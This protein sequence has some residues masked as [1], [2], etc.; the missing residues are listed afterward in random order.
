MEKD[1][2]KKTIR[3]KYV[4]FWDSDAKPFYKELSQFYN[5]ELSDQPDYVFFGVHDGHGRYGE[6]HLTYNNCIKILYSMECFTP[7][8]NLCDYAISF[9]RISF[10]DRY[11][12]WPGYCIIEC[13][14]VNYREIAFLM[15]K[16]HENV[17][18]ILDR[19]TDFCSFV[20]SNGGADPIR[21]ATF[22]ALNSYKRVN[23]GGRFL[24]NIGLPPGVG[25]ADKL[26]FQKKHKFSLTFENC[27]HPGYETE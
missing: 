14:N 13:E 9:D 17:E 4:D 15:Q 7:D 12:R 18:G 10:G 6:S 20:V 24:N 25:V 1:L 27:S 21:Q 2:Q 26:E 19:K 22:E 5:V 16:K 3:V 23:S 8:F 11:L